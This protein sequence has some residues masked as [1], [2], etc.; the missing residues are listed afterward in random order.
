MQAAK[1]AV[2]SCKLTP[3]IPRARHRPTEGS[4]LTAALGRALA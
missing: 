1:M 3:Y 4:S 2:S